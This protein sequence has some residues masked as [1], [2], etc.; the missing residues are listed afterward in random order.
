MKNLYLFKGTG[1]GKIYAD[2]SVGF[3]GVQ[4]SENNILLHSFIIGNV[5]AN[6]CATKTTHA[7]CI[8]EPTVTCGWCQQT[9]ECFEAAP[10]NR[11]GKINNNKPSNLLVRCLS[12]LSKMF[13]FDIHRTIRNE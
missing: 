10:D 9:N 7:T 12:F 2:I 1:S 13:I 11:T 6:P 8:A 3:T 4:F 5:A